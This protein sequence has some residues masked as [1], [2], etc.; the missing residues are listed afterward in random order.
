MCSCSVHLWAHELHCVGGA[1]ALPDHLQLNIFPWWLVTILFTLEHRHQPLPQGLPVNAGD[2]GAL[3]PQLPA[4]HPAVD[5]VPLLLNISITT[6][7]RE[8]DKLL[9]CGGH[10]RGEKKEKCIFC[11][12]WYISL[13]RLIL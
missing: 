12:W 6:W 13:E 4:L 10:G 11:N 9:L 1:R 8:V 7:L 3:V 5:V 2:D